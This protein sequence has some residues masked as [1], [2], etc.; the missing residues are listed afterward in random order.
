MEKKEGYFAEKL[1]SLANGAGAGPTEDGA[2]R[3]RVAG[4]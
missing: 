4:S 3:D 2:G 1:L